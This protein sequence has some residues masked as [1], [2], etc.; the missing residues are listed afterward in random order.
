M[1]TATQQPRLSRALILE[2]GLRIADAE[3]LEAL[4]MR[5]LAA[6]L[7]V[8]P[9]TA[10]T[11]VRTKEELVDGVAALVL[12][13]LPIEDE[14]GD[15][16]QKRLEH[17]VHALYSALLEHPG[18]AQIVPSRRGPIPAL[19]RFRETLLTILDDAGFKPGVAVQAVSALA[20]YAEG[21]AATAQDR[22]GADPK[23]EASRLR[24]LPRDD[25]PRLSASAD[26]YA[27]HISEDAFLVGLRSLIAGLDA[28]RT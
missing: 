20:S 3:G 7:D 24:G 22:A 19:D 4:T 11:Y 8:A 27:R 25:F 26:L 1:T 17:A 9:M 21:F 14:P 13:E 2:A 18:V 28:R 12:A 15:P 5:R 23:V 10:Y 16:W 6:E